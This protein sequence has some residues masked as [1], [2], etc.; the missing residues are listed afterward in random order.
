[1]VG[2]YIPSVLIDTLEPQRDFA[3]IRLAA[4]QKSIACFAQGKVWVCGLDGNLGCYTLD[5]KLGGECFL[6]KEFSLLD[7]ETP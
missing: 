5:M 3:F 4:P 1:M 7:T 2:Q 6:T